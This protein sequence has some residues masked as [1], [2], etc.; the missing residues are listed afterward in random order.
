MPIWSSL[1]CYPSI[2]SDLPEPQNFSQ[3]ATLEFVGNKQKKKLNYDQPVNV[4]YQGYKDSKNY[5]PVYFNSNVKNE[6]QAL[7]ARV[8]MERPQPTQLMEFFTIFVKTYLN[9]LLP[10]RR[11]RSDTIEVYIQNSNAAPSVKR[12]ILEAAKK[13][14][15]Q[16]INEHSSLS[17]D[18]LYLYTTRKSF[19]KVENLNYSSDGGVKEKAPRLIQGARP[20]FVSIVGPFF[21]AFQRYMKK[22]WNKDNFLYFT[23]GA[24]NKTMGEFLD[25]N[26]H[27]NIFENDVSAWDASFS[28]ELCKLE[29]WVAGQFGAPKCV[30]DLMKEN[31][32]THGRTTNGWKYACKGTRKSGDPYTSCFNSLFN[33]LLHLFVFHLQT[34]IE[35]CDF[36]DTIRMMVMGDD[37]LMRHTGGEVN[38]FDDLLQLGFVTES[39]YRDSYSEVEFCSSIPVP[40]LQGTVFVPKPGKLI[41][42]F[43]Y[44]VQPPKVDSDQLLYGVCCG[45]EFLRFIPWYSSLLDGALSSIKI[46]NVCESKCYDKFVGNTEHKYKFEK[47]DWCEMTD[48]TLMMRYGFD[49]YMY[50]TCSVALKRGDMGHP[51]VQAL[52]DRETA[53]VKTIYN[54]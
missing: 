35:V 44:F 24:T 53:G 12:T 14:N 49:S 3:G 36:K 9:D 17:Q 27:W 33:A 52:F 39:K 23:S 18:S 46:K 31:I 45:L 20:E 11:I 2:V 1:K 7:W 25:V 8:L 29:V 16:G 26:K 37:N 48:Y 15:E 13:L 28:T 6:Q 43:G 5:K 34:G 30:I 38:F 54:R 51:F 19:V 41:S 32:N 21:S 4:Q 40:S 42:K 50:A 22:M 47:V 10:I